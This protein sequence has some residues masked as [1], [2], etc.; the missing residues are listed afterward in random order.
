[1][2]KTTVRDSA[3]RICDLDRRAQVA[4]ACCAC[5]G[6]IMDC[7]SCASIN[8]EELGELRSD[9]DYSCRAAARD[10]RRRA[11]QARDARSAQPLCGPWIYQREIAAPER[12]RCLRKFSADRRGTGALA[13]ERN[14]R[15]PR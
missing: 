5:E 6:S 11:Q 15:T 9:D 4:L 10:Q 3:A 1:M 2:A 7:L 8:T 14:V 12:Q 13:G